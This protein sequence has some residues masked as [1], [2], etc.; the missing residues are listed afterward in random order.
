MRSLEARLP[1]NLAWEARPGSHGSQSSSD[2]VTEEER[3]CGPCWSLGG[4]EALSHGQTSLRV[5]APPQRAPSAQG[6]FRKN[7]RRNMN[8]TGGATMTPL[9]P[10]SLWRPPAAR[11]HL[12]WWHLGGPRLPASDHTCWAQ[13]GACLLAGSLRQNI[14]VHPWCP[15][16][17][18]TPAFSPRP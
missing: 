7:K 8:K 12:Q 16:F 18:P 6:L 2:R 15:R 17:K 14:L 11:L 5:E 4:R 9:G 13:R 1:G 10:S 3:H